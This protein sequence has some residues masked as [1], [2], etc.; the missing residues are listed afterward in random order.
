MP[1]QFKF[2]TIPVK[3]AEEIEVELN[4]FLRSVKVLTIQKE[5]IVQGDNSFWAYVVEYLSV[6][7][8]LSSRSGKDI[9]NIIDYKELLSPHDFSI[10][11]RLRE[12]RKEIAVQDSLPVYMI[13]TNEQLAAMAEQKVT[14]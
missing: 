4:K 6:A 13:F 14:S 2:F 10:F 11:A 8:R 9:K 3:G 12:W 5:L 1:Q 7:S